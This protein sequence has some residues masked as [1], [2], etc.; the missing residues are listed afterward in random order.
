MWIRKLIATKEFG[1]GSGGNLEITFRLGLAG[2][3]GQTL[4]RI[5]MTGMGNTTAVKMTTGALECLGQT[6]GDEQGRLNL[7]PSGLPQSQAQGPH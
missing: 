1:L 7:Q 5:G 6:W 2:S 4:D 3:G